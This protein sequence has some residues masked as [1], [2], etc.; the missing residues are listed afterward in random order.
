MAQRRI[1]KHGVFLLPHLR[2]GIDLLDCGC[3]PG[4]MTVELARQVLPGKTVGLDRAAGQFAESERVALQE[5]LPLTFESGDVTALPF[6]D[7]SFD[8]VFAHALIE[9]LADP[10]PAVREFARVLRPNGITA[11]RSPDWGGFVLHPYPADVQQAIRS[12]CDLM[13]ANGGDPFA[14]RKLAALLRDGG[15]QDV[16]STAAYE[17]YEDPFLIAEYL[18]EQLNRTNHMSAQT[19]RDWAHDRDALFAQAWIEARGR[20]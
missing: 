2:A 3:G 9:H 6:G 19:L 4:T 13:L 7:S 11:F 20:R 10:A 5:G 12:Y 15:F 8:V 18:A 14:G 16:V 1:E 17:V